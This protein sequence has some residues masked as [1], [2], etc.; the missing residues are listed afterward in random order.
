MPYEE[1]MPHFREA[2][3]EEAL[4]LV[5]RRLGE[6]RRERLR[7]HRLAGSAKC[8]NEEA[9][10]FQKL[11]HRLPHQQRR[12]LHRLPRPVRGA[13]RGC[14]LWRGLDHLRRHRSL[15][16]SRS[17]P[18]A[19]RPPTT[20]GVVVL[21]AGA[22]PRHKIIYDPRGGTVAEHADIFC[23]SSQHRCGALQRDHAEVIFGLID[24]DFI[25][26]RT[27]N[28]DQLAKTVQAYPPEL[29]A[30]ITG[31]DVE[32]IRE[33]AE[34]VGRGQCRRHLLGHGHLPAHHRHRQLPLPDRDV[35]DHRQRRPAGHRAASAA[36]SE[37][38]AG[39]IRRG[40]DPD[41]LP[42]LPVGL[43]QQGPGAV[44]AGVGH[45]ARS[46]PG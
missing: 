23:N 13:V 43:V 12:P 31:L 4:D 41:V 7:R 33:V 32:Q 35:R 19:T 36:R 2:S 25:A 44:R 18:A 28:Y 5:A 40:A 26:N 39:R 42:G 15:P 17:S 16:T 21:Q 45:R 11:I 1:V 6:S 9:Y 22:A 29:G 34:A 37:Q 46:G 8:S 24:R 30:Q 20:G 38:R 3:W 10:L 27:S 14:R